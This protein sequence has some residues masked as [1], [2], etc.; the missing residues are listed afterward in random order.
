MNHGGMN[1]GRFERG[2]IGDFVAAR[3]NYKDQVLLG[4]ASF[5]G[6]SQQR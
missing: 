3:M 2:D 1:E 4:E 5:C 6:E